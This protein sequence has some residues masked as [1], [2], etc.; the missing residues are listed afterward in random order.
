MAGVAAQRAARHDPAW[1]HELLGGHGAH[2]V[3]IWRTTD[4]HPL[5][6]AAAVVEWLKGTGLLPFL[7]RLR[8]EETGDF[9]DRYAAAIAA[10]YPALPGG[11]V[12]LPFPRP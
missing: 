7:A 10:A 6:G 5:A 8:P 12:L 11:T 2:A 3:D 4:D 1:Y 9:L